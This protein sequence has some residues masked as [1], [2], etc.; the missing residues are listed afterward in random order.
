MTQQLFE[1]DRSSVC[2]VSSNSTF[3]FVTLVKI[4]ISFSSELLPPK[5]TISLIFNVFSTPSFSTPTT[6]FRVSTFST[7]PM[8]FV[9]A[10]QSLIFPAIKSPLLSYKQISKLI[11]IPHWQVY[12]VFFRLINHI[13]SVILMIKYSNVLFLQCLIDYIW[14]NIP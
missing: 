7:I 9:S 14:L 5:T 8:Q 12:C 11:N 10:K 6:T 1:Y 4:P 2:S 3:F 13:F